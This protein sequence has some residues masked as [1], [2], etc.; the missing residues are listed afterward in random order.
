M[1]QMNPKPENFPAELKTKPNWVAWRKQTKAPVNP[2]NL[3]NAKSNDPTTWG[4]VAEALKA[5]QNVPGRI[6]GVGIN[7]VQELVVVD[8]DD[9]CPGGKL[10]DE[11]LD[12]ITKTG[13]YWEFS[14]SGNGLKGLF[15]AQDGM[16]YLNIGKTKVHFHGIPVA[17]V[18][19]DGKY[20]TL[21]G[22]L[23]KPEL[24]KIQP[25]DGFV[26]ALLVAMRGQ[27]TEFTTTAPATIREEKAE[28]ITTAKP[29]PARIIATRTS[30]PSVDEVWDILQRISADCCY[31][32]RTKVGM[33]IHSWDSGQAGEAL[34]HKWSQTAPHR[35]KP[36]K[37]EASWRGFKRDG[38]NQGKV[39]LGTLKH[40]A[41]R[42]PVEVFPDAVRLMVEDVARVART[43]VELGGPIALGVLSGCIGKGLVVKQAFGGNDALPTIQVCIFAPS[44]SGKSATTKPFTKKL[45]E[46]IFQQ[47]EDI[48]LKSTKLKAR[49]EFIEATIQRNVKAY[50][51]E[52]STSLVLENE[53]LGAELA[54]IEA[55]LKGTEF[56]VEDVTPERLAVVLG[57]NGANG[58]ECVFS[59]SLDARKAVAVVL[60]CYKKEHNSPDDTLY[61][62]TFSWDPHNQQRQGN[63]RSVDLKAPA[64][65][66]LWLMQPDLADK[67]LGHPE[68]MASGF[69][70]RLT[71]DRI[72][73]EPSE[74][75]EPVLEDATA[76]KGWDRLIFQ[77]LERF[78]TRNQPLEIDTAEGVREMMLG[79]YNEN[80]RRIKTGELADVETLAVRFAEMAWRFALILH[81]AR[82]GEQA[83]QPLEAV[84]A[85]D[86]ITLARYYAN[87]KLALMLASRD[88]RDQDRIERVGGLIDRWGH[89]TARR[90]SQFLHELS[91]ERWR[92]W[93]EKKALERVFLRAEVTHE[94]GGPR[95]VQ[96]SRMPTTNAT[97]A[98]N[99][100][101]VE[102]S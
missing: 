58:Q 24:N 71:M 37:M 34:W 96:F 41:N 9:V 54:E 62:K 90:L 88:K 82:H 46:W 49:A 83:D 98:T 74:I 16:G 13:S 78:R 66:L 38:N 42:F 92:G 73:N 44:G 77:V 8:F 89:V 60:G 36:E 28:P 31:D 1:K 19:N 63:E 100:T 68:L 80:I 27:Q 5:F 4:T 95:S 6:G 67:L 39:T 18:W 57:N 30:G 52:P 10:S 86:G 29:I 93:L 11:V 59:L 32:E 40:L 94:G 35:Y 55:Q 26:D 56:L 7:P 25:M 48:R 22:N 50:G 102:R 21:T 53:T 3:A 51:K 75:L 97:N 45:N 91:T 61:V 64:L 72:H 85:R 69:I 79:Y 76:R 23:V 81:V 84:S 70:Q 47:K 65:P 20:T 2:R 12:A 87:R 101:R 15:F 99:E 43:P 14:P 17:E 33:G